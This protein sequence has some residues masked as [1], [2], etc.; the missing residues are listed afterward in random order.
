[1]YLYGSEKAGDAHVSG[2]FTIDINNDYI[3]NLCVP[4]ATISTRWWRCD[5]IIQQ[6]L[7]Y[8]LDMICHMESQPTPQLT[9]KQSRIEPACVIVPTE[10][11]SR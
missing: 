11:T 1:M 8:P 9:M 2:H 7:V 5:I 3:S 10:E 6:V 4:M